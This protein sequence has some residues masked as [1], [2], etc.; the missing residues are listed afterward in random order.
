M[1]SYQKVHFHSTP[2]SVISLFRNMVLEDNWRAAVNQLQ[3]AITP[4]LSFTQI[5]GLLS[6]ELDF[7]DE[8]QISSASQSS[9]ANTLLAKWHNVS[10]HKGLW[11]QPIRFAKLDPSQVPELISQ[12]QEEF[13]EISE[14]CRFVQ[15]QD[16]NPHEQIFTH[17]NYAVVCTTIADPPF[18]IKSLSPKEVFETYIEEACC[19]TP[20]VDEL[21]SLTLIAHEVLAPCSYNNHSAAFVFALNKYYE[22]NE[23]TTVSASTVLTWLKGWYYGYLVREQAKEQGGFFLLKSEDQEWDVPMAPFIQWVINRVGYTSS[24]SISSSLLEYA[25]QLSWQPISPTGLKMGGDD[26]IHTDWILGAGLTPQEAYWTEHPLNKAAWKFVLQVADQEGFNF[27][28]LA[29]TRKTHGHVIHLKDYSTQSLSLVK[30]GHIVVV[31]EASP[32][33]AVLIPILSKE[34]GGAIVCC[35]G[36]KLSHLAIVAAESKVPVIVMADAYSQLIPQLQYE[37][38]MESAQVRLM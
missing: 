38:D 14:L 28:K 23:H 32:E 15:L 19:A 10:Q 33:Y 1:Y 36:G 2:L 30:P 27:V 3:K 12:F 24:R 17:D 34:K 26:V 11:Y 13:F 22:L 37:I 29:G 5:V 18:W 35:T 31:P 6:G 25:T 21:T 8:G 4:E 20:V 16:L 9:Y 7:N